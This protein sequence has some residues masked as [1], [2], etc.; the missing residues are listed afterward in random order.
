M[1]SSVVA[2]MARGDDATV[3]GSAR[4]G[5][6][7]P[8]G[9]AFQLV[10]RGSS[11]QLVELPGHRTAPLPGRQQA[12]Y[13]GPSSGRYLTDDARNPSRTYNRRLSPLE[14]SRNAGRPSRSSASR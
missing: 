9:R 3:G 11:G 4:P 1:P 10:A 14:A 6:P 7:T 12:Q 2:L 5:T 8:P 13:G